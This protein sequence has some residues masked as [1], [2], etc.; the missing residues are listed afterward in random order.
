[1]RT[2]AS[3]AVRPRNRSSRCSTRRCPE[4]IRRLDDVG[5]REA[6]STR[7]LVS[8]RKSCA[9]SIVAACQ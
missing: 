8:D 9:G 4:A 3:H 2:A 7:T 1:M 5:L 6:A